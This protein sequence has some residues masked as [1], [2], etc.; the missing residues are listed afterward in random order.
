MRQIPVSAMVAWAAC[1][2]N[3]CET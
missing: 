1:A 2:L 3:Q